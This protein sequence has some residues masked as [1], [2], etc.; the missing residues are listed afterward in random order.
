VSAAVA[1]VDR[2]RGVSTVHDVRYD[3]LVAVLCAVFLGGAYL[4][5][6]AHVHVPE[7]ETFFTPWHAV[8]YAG[9]F[10]VSAVTIA[11]LL[12]RRAPGT[13]WSEALPTGYDR[14]VVGVL[15]FALG[16]VLDMLW[17]L[18]FGVEA[19]VEALLSPS[20]LVL[21][22][23][24]A[25][26][27]T[28]PLRAAWH[29]TDAAAPWPAILSLALLL[30]MCSF[31]TQYAH[32]FGRP[33]PAAGNR[34]T[35]AVFATV[36]PDPVFRNAEIQNLYV[37]HGF[38]VGAVL[39]QAA[40]LSAMVLLAVRRW[41]SQLP[42][43]AFTLVFGFNALL[44]GAARD[45]LHLLPGAIA[46]GIAADAL[47]WALQPSSSHTSSLRWFAFAVP[48]V[49]FGLYF[50]NIALTRGVWWSVPLWS[51]AIALAGVV[52]WLASWLVI[53]P[54]IPDSARR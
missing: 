14:S 2:R 8:F 35:A 3:A 46:G 40:V 29:R 16:G 19:D 43:G 5:V 15:V 20:H 31:F 54:P 27:V 38:G 49:Y 13:T 50:I 7:L 52:G 9:F 34:P 51:G 6:W 10:A 28:G 41:G 42:V 4:D 36:A 18:V 30:S 33:W 53:P 17:H 44:I 37:A 21:A 47:L 39:L 25:L 1:D 45:Q 12:R 24:A 32:H 23:G 22:T 26:F 11:P 48:T